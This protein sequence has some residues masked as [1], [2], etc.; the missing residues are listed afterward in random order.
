MK[1]LFALLLSFSAQAQTQ[2]FEPRTTPQVEPRADV[3]MP[4]IPDRGAVSATT[5]A[6][7]AAT[8]HNAARAQGGNEGTG[9]GDPIAAE[10]SS[11]IDYVSTYLTQ[12]PEIHPG[13]SRSALSGLASDVA[14]SLHVSSKQGKIEVVD[15]GKGAGPVFLEN[16]RT[17]LYIKISR[18]RWQA[19]S[20]KARLQE[21]IRL[22]VTMTAVSDD[23]D[24]PLPQSGID[25]YVQA[26]TRCVEYT[27]AVSI[28]FN[29]HID[30]FDRCNKTNAAKVAAVLLTIDQ[31]LRK[32][33]G[34]CLSQCIY[35]KQRI[36]GA[37]IC[38]DYLAQHEVNMNDYRRFRPECVT[39]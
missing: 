17:P 9:G 5:S 35:H 24:I 34:L 14:N 38:S 20:D 31:A 3:A 32:G 23:A 25:S 37:E 1:I 21:V 11:L 19:L 8:A 30:L 7:A 4:Q 18:I 12:H 26:Y 22:M 33:V 39:P 27:E 2:P 28:I 15:E 13:I 29:R 16:S 6:A 36:N 10:F